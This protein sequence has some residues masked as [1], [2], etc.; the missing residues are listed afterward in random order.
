MEHILALVDAIPDARWRLAFQLM[1]A[2]GLRPE[3][4]QQGCG[5]ARRGGPGPA[6]RAAAAVLPHPSATE[7]YRSGDRESECEEPLTV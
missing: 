2:Y 1:A 5:D 3:E 6:A 7:R 4:L